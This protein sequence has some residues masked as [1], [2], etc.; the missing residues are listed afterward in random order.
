MA[1]EP[2][3]QAGFADAQTDLHSARRWWYL[4]LSVSLG[5]GFAFLLL[6]GLG[7]F[8]PM[9]LVRAA[10]PTRLIVNTPIDELNSDGDCS[11]RE[12]IQAAKH[13]HGSGW[14]CSGQ[15]C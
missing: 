5:L 11:L 15:W 3:L 1:S 9:P 10:A 8:G 14:L 2:I 12:A 4:G 6:S 7:P 13:E